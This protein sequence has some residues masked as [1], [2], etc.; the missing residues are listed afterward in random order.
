MDVQLG[1]CWRCENPIER[2]V[3]C[4]VCGES[5]YCSEVCRF[6]D[7]WRHI[8]E[9]VEWRPKQCSNA[10]CGIVSGQLKECTACCD[11]WY[12]GETC[13]RQHWK[14]HK[15]SCQKRTQE[16][17]EVGAALK[18]NFHNYPKF[19]SE[20]AMMQFP[21]YIGN[22]LAI[23]MLNLPANESRREDER[24]EKT[25][26]LDTLEDSYSI[27]SA[28]CGNIRN[29]IHTVASLPNEFK[30][31]LHTVLNDCDIYVQARNVLQLYMMIMYSDDPNVAER[32]T[33]IWYSLHLPEEDYKFLIDCLRALL[34]FSADS[35]D[36]VT[37]G[38]LKLS[39]TDITAI[40]PVWKAWLELE[41]RE[42][43]PN[44]I[45]LQE[46]RRRLLYQNQEME[47]G[48]KL[49]RKELPN[50]LL[51]SFDEYDKHGNFIPGVNAESCNLPYDNPTLTG[52]MFTQSAQVTPIESLLF[53]MSGRFVYCIDNCLMAFSEWDYLKVKKHHYNKSMVVMFHSFIS[54]QIKQTIASIKAGAQRV[55]IIICNCFDISARVDVESDRFDRIFTSNIVDFSGTQAL[56]KVMKPL[57]NR[58]NKSSTIITQHYG[59]Y[60]SVPD[61]MV[62]GEITAAKTTLPAP[63]R[64]C[65]ISSCAILAA[66]DINSDY[67]E[68][69]LSRHPS[70]M[71]EECDKVIDAN[72]F[73]CQEYFNNMNW[74]VSYL[75]AE[76]MAVNKDS[77]ST[78]PPSFQ[79]VKQSEGLQLRDFRRGNSNK[80]VPFRYRRNA[81]PVNMTRGMDRMLEWHFA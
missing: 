55:S 66:Y 68:D 46:Q 42:G 64:V 81:R 77:Q 48:M 21:Y 44:Y 29:W 39:E 58:A 67:Y 40:R 28:G 41:C 73:F 3:A 6:R 70:T 27:L 19:S 37:G 25:S 63:Q 14:D 60:L 13:Q 31:T 53:L 33:T 45:D 20:K 49:Y 62:Y 54:D 23:D 69:M 11:A 22:T 36:E 61:S 9:C 30:G 59:W 75:R 52:Y 12:C 24:T 79:K 51:Q 4:I 57:L 15:P 1:C 5:K 71:T 50:E 76:C 38:A 78:N 35:L 80:V 72:M 47:E 26:E 74:F 8:S 18:V 10:K 56:L 16:I 65:E 7:Q 2:D 43:H 32:I 34:G 17:R